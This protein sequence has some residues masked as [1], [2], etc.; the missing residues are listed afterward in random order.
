MVAW[1]LASRF[2]PK[3][4]GDPGHDRN[5]RT[6]QFACFLLAAT[7]SAIALLN[8]ITR[9]PGATRVL[10]FAVAGLF[11]A[12]IMNRAGRWQWAARTAIL[13]LLLTATLLVLD[14]HDGFRSHAMLVFPGMLLISVMLLD[15]ASYL[16]T[17]GIVLVAVVALGIAERKGLTRAIPRVRS[18]TTYES[19]FIV[20]V[21]LLVFALIGSRIARDGQLNVFDLRDSIESLCEANLE[22]TE[23]AKALSESEQQVVS[24]YN[25]VRDV[26]FHLAVEPEGRFRF[27]SVNAAFLRVTGLSREMVVGKTVNEVI[28]EPSLTM[29]LGKYRDAVAQHTTVLW[30]ETSDYPTGQLTGEVSVTP[31]FDKAGKCTH[32]VGSVHD[33]TEMRRAQKEALARQKLETVGTLAKG[34]AHDF[35]NILGGVLAQTDLALTELDSGSVPKG[36]LMAIRGAAMRGAEIVRELL[37]YAGTENPA[38]TPLDISQVVDEMLGLLK[39]SVSKHA[40]IETDLAKDLPAVR[41]NPGQISQLVMNLVT[42]ASEAI[43]DRKGV[44]RVITGRVTAGSGTATDPDYLQLEVSDTGSGMTPETKAKVFEPFFSTKSAGAV[45]G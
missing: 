23:T 13:A 6:V 31:V 37:I 25:T 42:N 41:A 7:V 33:I 3:T 45:S 27:L 30:E 1:K 16:I 39:V 32:L 28:P 29:V 24:I 44:I 8:V 34:I 12:I 21:N 2:Y 11:A 17:A 20:D 18:S 40:T 5:A 14:A 38:L 4:T 9:E 35:N 22:L 15:R 10:A 36:E 19:I 26:I 43:G